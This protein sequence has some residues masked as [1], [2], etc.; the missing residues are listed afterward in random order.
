MHFIWI[1]WN[2]H[3]LCTWPRA[4]TC[5]IIFGYLATWILLLSFFLDTCMKSISWIPSEWQKIVVVLFLCFVW[6]L[7]KIAFWILSINSNIWII[8]NDSQPFGYLFK[9]HFGYLWNNKSLCF[10]ELW[11]L[12]SFIRSHVA[13]SCLHAMKCSACQTMQ[14]T[15]ETHKLMPRTPSSC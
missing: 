10:P 9:I 11:C 13:L 6:I 2:S 15:C 12:T 14:H 4:E 3:S 8:V 5:V 7:R 1:L